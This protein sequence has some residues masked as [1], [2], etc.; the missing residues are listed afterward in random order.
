MSTSTKTGLAGPA[1]A[2]AV[3]VVCFFGYQLFFAP[4]A[5]TTPTKPTTPE[6]SPIESPAP[7]PA[8]PAPNSSQSPT[9]VTNTE[10]PIAKTWPTYH[11]GADL[12]GY[13]DLQLPDKL[14]VLWQ[15]V[16]EGD[17]RHAVVGDAQSLYFASTD[18][19]VVSLDFTGKE[20]WKKPIARTS[21]EGA[22]PTTERINA[23][24]SVFRST[25]L[26]GSQSGIMYALKAQD[27]ETKWTFDVGGEVLGAVNVYE[28]SDPGAP[29]L[30]Y[31]IE[32]EHGVLHAV[33]LDNGAKVWQTDPIARTDGSMAVANGVV[34]YG[35][36]DFALHTYGAPQG[37]RGQVIALC[38]DCQVAS[39]PALVG[40]EIYSGSR[41]GHFYRA[42]VKTGAVVWMNEECVKEIFT[43][44]ALAK[45][46]VVFGSEDGNVY[47]LDRATGKQRWKFEA[48]GLPTSSIIASNKVIFGTDGKLIMLA[49]DS[50]AE[51]WR[52]E[53]SDGIASPSIIDGM[54]VVGSEDGTVIVFGAKPAA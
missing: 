15:Y 13:S 25:V 42:D 4:S 9:N 38:S 39:G 21:A 41:S 43:T 3:I 54:V 27:G 26:V 28:P 32:R 22:A 49:L 47:C 31:A 7:T 2:I 18:G 8:T 20:R 35:S 48:G 6:P 50:G 30:A 10:V 51:I 29:A 45:D 36:C 5:P 12:C 52:Y 16:A 33:R 53:V 24:L 17:I 44:P 46:V 37:T 14:D 11:G 40:D 19:L 34:A 23:P 1:I